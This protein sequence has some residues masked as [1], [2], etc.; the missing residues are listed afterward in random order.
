[1]LDVAPEPEPAFEPPPTS[2]PA[3][4]PPEPPK[5]PVREEAEV[6]E[7]VITTEA[8]E[9]PQEEPTREPKQAALDMLAYVRSIGKR[10][11]GTALGYKGHPSQPIRA[12]QQD[13]GT[14]PDG[15]YGPSDR[16]RGRQ[17][18]GQKFPPR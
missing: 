7:T 10:G 13:M 5:P 11:R 6:V 14:T 18:T 3:P 2:I 1:M 15:I 4:P 9:T 16:E 17:L 8:P 12:A